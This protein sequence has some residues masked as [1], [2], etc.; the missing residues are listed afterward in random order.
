MEQTGQP[1]L[2]GKYTQLDVT[3]GQEDVFSTSWKVRFEVNGYYL[4]LSLIRLQATDELPHS[5][6]HIVIT[7]QS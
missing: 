4:V 2:I 6:P 5:V 1:A 3:G 7:R